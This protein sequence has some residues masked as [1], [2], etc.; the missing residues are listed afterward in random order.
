MY[1]YVCKED[2][3]RGRWFLSGRILSDVFM[4]KGAEV[5]DKPIQY[6]YVTVQGVLGGAWVVPGWCLKLFHLGAVKPKELRNLQVT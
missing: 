3:S 5:E 2:L 6:A 1:I 4:G